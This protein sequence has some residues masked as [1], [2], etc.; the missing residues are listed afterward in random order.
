MWVKLLFFVC[1]MILKN[2]FTLNL[3][4]E[5]V[6]F[7]LVLDS[8]QIGFPFVY[9]KIYIIHFKDCHRICNTNILSYF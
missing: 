8:K 3:H 6:L 2:K 4:F 9:L 1:M 5:I 7:Y